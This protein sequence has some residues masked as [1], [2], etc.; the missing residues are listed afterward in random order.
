[1]HFHVQQIK[2]LARYEEK[3]CETRGKKDRAFID[4]LSCSKT[5]SWQSVTEDQE[6]VFRCVIISTEKSSEEKG[7][8]FFPCVVILDCMNVCWTTIVWIRMGL[9][10]FISRLYEG[11]YLLLESK[12]C[13]GGITP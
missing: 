11:I 10:N 7:G 8:S 13:I 2:R 12:S 5:E 1:M 6:V 4:A 9:M 3:E